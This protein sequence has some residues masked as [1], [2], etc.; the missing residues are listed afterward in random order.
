MTRR[1]L[2]ALTARFTLAMTLFLPYG[3]RGSAAEKLL[4]DL[5][6]GGRHDLVLVQTGLALRGLELEVVAH[7][8]L[9]LLDLAAAGD[10]EALLGPGVG[11]L[12]RHLV[13]LLGSAANSWRTGV[14]G[15]RLG[16]VGRLRLG[17]VRGI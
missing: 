7:P 14:L 12:L 6:V 16:G 15:L 8:G 13:V 17:L 1:F 10:L 9:L 5:G 3:S 11:L 2:W 4:D